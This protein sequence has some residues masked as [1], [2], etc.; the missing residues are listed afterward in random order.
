MAK[1]GITYSVV[2][3][4]AANIKNI[5]SQISSLFTD[6]LCGGV[7]SSI[8]SH[9]DG[10]AAESYKATFTKL[11]NNANESL[12]KVVTEMTQKINETKAAYQSQDTKLS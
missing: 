4:M 9:Y 8:A 1:S 2:D 11:G 5:Q 12:N 3:T 6:E 10:Q 7:V